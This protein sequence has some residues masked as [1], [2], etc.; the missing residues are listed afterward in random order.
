MED[1]EEEAAINASLAALDCPVF[2][3]T[4]KDLV[5]AVAYWGEGVVLVIVAF[6][7]VVGNTLSGFIL[8]GRSMRNSFNLL[9]IA[10]AVFDNTYLIGA[11]LEAVR[12]R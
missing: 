3:Q 5:D 4:Q 1:A 11:I 8:A 7:G 2:S 10:L 9:L 12:K 6:A